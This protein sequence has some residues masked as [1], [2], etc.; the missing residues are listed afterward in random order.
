MGFMAILTTQKSKSVAQ[1]AE[2]K[3]IEIIVRSL[4][5]AC[6]PFP[7]GP[8][9][10]C[11]IIPQTEKAKFRVSTIDSVILGRHF[12]SS[13]SGSLAGMKLVERNLSDLAAA[14]AKPK[15]A[16]LSL[17]IGPNV[18]L[19]WLKDFA[20]AV[21]RA[22]SRAG[23]NINGGDVCRVQ[24]GQFSATLSV[25]GFSQ[26]I[27][28]RTTCQAGDRLFVTGELGGSLLGH[29]CHF[30]ARVAEG[31]WLAQQKS[32][33][34][35]TDLSDGMLKDLPGLIGKKWDAIV[36]TDRLPLRP[37]AQ[38]MAKKD[39]RSALEHALQDGEDYELLFCV[40]A[41]DAS[42]FAQK[43][44]KQFPKT[45]LSEIG[46]IKKGKGLVRSLKDKQ[47]FLGKGFSHFA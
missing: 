25:Q 3:L 29:H 5:R 26:R 32:T 41:K 44:Q 13:C 1:V 8:G 42:S 27:L 34:A 18:N 40:K 22:A 36:D 17:F 15:D 19:A 6:P 11:A 23:M 45:R 43:F 14:G 16:L 2:E 20:Q 9:G 10:D 30:R 12:D 37:A 7:A 24:A 28:T 21:G 47:P 4:G 46:F 39:G 31:L 33:T 35:C 38:Q